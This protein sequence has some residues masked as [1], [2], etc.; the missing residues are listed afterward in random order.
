MP[1]LGSLTISYE[2]HLQGYTNII[3]FENILDKLHLIGKSEEDVLPYLFAEA[4][5]QVN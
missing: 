2:N 3:Y 1:C 5:Y 4:L